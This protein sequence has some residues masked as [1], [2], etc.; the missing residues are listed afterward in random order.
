MVNT[1]DKSLFRVVAL[2]R[3]RSD[4]S[5]FG[6]TGRAGYGVRTGGGADALVPGGGTVDAHGEVVISF[7]R[8]KGTSIVIRRHVPEAAHLC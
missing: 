4:R 3:G 8:F 7:A 1:L 5:E 2:D 6:A